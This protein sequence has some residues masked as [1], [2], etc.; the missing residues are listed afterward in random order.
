MRR[1]G[2]ALIKIVSINDGYVPSA[3]LTI[4]FDWNSP[5]KQQTII[6]TQQ[7]W[8]KVAINLMLNLIK[9]SF[10]ILWILREQK[11]LFLKILC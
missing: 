2:P 8:S 7:V 6:F 1:V 11:L 4:S 5:K 10:M 3:A 9:E